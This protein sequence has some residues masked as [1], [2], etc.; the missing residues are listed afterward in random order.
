VLAG[1]CAHI[2]ARDARASRVKHTTALAHEYGASA[3]VDL[4]WQH[5]V[6]ADA[7]HVDRALI[8]TRTT[9]RRRVHVDGSEE[10]GIRTVLLLRRLCACARAIGHA[11]HLPL[12]R[13]VVGIIVFVLIFILVIVN[14]RA[15]F[16]VNISTG[17][18]REAR[19]AAAATTRRTQY[20]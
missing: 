9:Q 14:V 18:P 13:L 7:A 12:P 4:A 19:H 2:G 17:A 1:R 8:E 16:A 5:R 10:R 20:S 15:R 3:A 11:A 6:D